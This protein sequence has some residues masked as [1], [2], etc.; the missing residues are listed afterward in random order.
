MKPLKK[1]NK[2]MQEI[3]SQFIRSSEAPWSEEFINAFKGIQKDVHNTAK[4]KGWWDNERNNGEAIALMHSE[5]SEAFEGWEELDDK[6]PDFTA[7][8]AE[9]ADCII[10]IMDMAE[11][12]SWNVA[13]S[14]Q[15]ELIFLQFS[16]VISL[17]RM[18]LHVHL[19]LSNALEAMRKPKE[20]EAKEIAKGL[21]DAVAAIMV[22]QNDFNYKVSDALC[23]KVEMNKTRERMHGGKKF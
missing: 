15:E 7:L 4:Q 12:R 14:L 23:A 2:I 6:V 19:G 16:D 21:A 9:L 1:K 13:N 8:E 5:L 10:R 20:N 18:I 11:A 22:I 3:Y 17:D